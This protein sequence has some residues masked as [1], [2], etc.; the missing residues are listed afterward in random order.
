MKIIFV[1]T[2]NT[3]RSPMAE[4]YFRAR[5]KNESFFDQLLISSAGLAA[6]A[7]APASEYAVKVMDEQGVGLT[8]FRSTQFKSYHMDYDLIV[9]MC[10]SHRQLIINYFPEAAEKTRLLMSFAPFPGADDVTDPFGGS[11][12]VYRSCFR[13]MK[14]GL[15]G[16][17]NY[18]T[19]KFE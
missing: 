12:A 11:L 5:C 6:S 17:F 3:C 8:D 18:V 14:R 19:E 7:G 16:L 2:G 15:D 4:A 10:D 9:P 13:Q 1:C